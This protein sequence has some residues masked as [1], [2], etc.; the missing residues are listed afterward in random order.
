MEGKVAKIERRIAKLEQTVQEDPES[1]PPAGRLDGRDHTVATAALKPEPQS[2][3]RVGGQ[4]SK[5]E[6]VAQI[7]A[8]TLAK[9]AK[10]KLEPKHEPEPEPGPVSQPPPSPPLHIYRHPP[11]GST[12]CI[13]LYMTYLTVAPK[14]AAVRRAPLPAA[15]GTVGEEGV[16]IHVRGIGVHEWGERAFPPCKIH[17]AYIWRI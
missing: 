12:P 3:P 6:M 14:A 1:A 15:P 5:E 4:M 13:Q 8:R 7:K 16:K 11:M 10:P 17:T 9:K 2:E